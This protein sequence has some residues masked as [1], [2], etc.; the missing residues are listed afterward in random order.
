MDNLASSP[1][2]AYSPTHWRRTRAVFDVALRIHRSIQE[3]DIEV[4]RNLGNRI[5]RWLDRLKPSANIRGMPHE[6]L[7]GQNN[8]NTKQLTNHPQKSS[9]DI[10]R[11]GNRSTEKGSGRQLFS[12][13][14]NTWSTSIPSIAMMMRPPRTQYRQLHANGSVLLKP[15]C[16]RLGVGGVFREDIMMWM[17]RN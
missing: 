5:L 6:K 16:T 15:N 7:P 2:F 13:A 17:H 10:Q 14:K 3:R 8:F 11:L 12:A 1:N 4:G 9:G